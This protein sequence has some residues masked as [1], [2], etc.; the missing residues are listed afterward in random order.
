MTQ[1]EQINDVN[2]NLEDIYIF[3][4]NQR[5]LH[6]KVNQIYEKQWVQVHIQEDGL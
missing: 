5:D 4:S 3:T 1:T 2:I 6:L